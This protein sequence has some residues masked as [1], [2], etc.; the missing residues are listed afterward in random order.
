MPPKGQPLF[1]L[2]EKALLA[3]VVLGACIGCAGIS[4][5]FD[6]MA[7]EA[8]F[9]ERANAYQREATLRFG[10]ADAVLTSLDAAVGARGQG[11]EAQALALSGELL[12]A[13][14][15]IQTSMHVPAD[16][17]SDALRLPVTKTRPATDADA[18]LVG[19]DFMAHPRLKAAVEGAMSS[20]A[21]VLTNLVDFLPSGPGFFLFRPFFDRSEIS[22]SRGEFAGLTS[23]YLDGARFFETVPNDFEDVSVW[24]VDLTAAIGDA[25]PVFQAIAPMRSEDAVVAFGAFQAALP[26]DVAGRVFWISFLDYPSIDEFNGSLAVL[27]GALPLIAGFFLANALASRRRGQHRLASV[28]ASLDRSEQRFK[29]FADASADL[30]WEMDSELRFSF[31]SDQY[32]TLTGVDAS[33]MLGRTRQQTGIPNVDPEVWRRHLDDLAAHRPFRDFIHPRTLP[34][35]STSWISVNGKPYFSDDGVFQG[36]RGTGREVTAQ[37]EHERELTEAKRAADAASRAKSEFLASMSHEL[38]TP[39][40]AVVGFSHILKSEPVKPGVNDEQIEFAEHIHHSGEHLLSLINDLLDLSKIESGKD[41]LN[42][43]RVDLKSLTRSAAT[44]VQNRAIEAG[45]EVVLDVPS[46]P[47]PLLADRRKVLQALVNMLSNA[48]KFTASGGKTTLSVFFE[49]DGACRIRVQDTGIGIAEADIPKALAAFSQVENTLCRNYEGTGLGLPLTKSLIEQHGG[50]L[51]LESE[52]G[53]G[54]TV[55]LAFPAWR[56]LK[57]EAKDATATAVV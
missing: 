49:D 34:D 41:E 22:P 50:E 24:L 12:A 30:Y 11:S 7:A 55:T 6:L 2:W 35:G 57:A 19:F 20:N 38:R 17:S 29:D 5:N 37:I 4:L 21:T 10:S 32:L 16:R 44:M 33:E 42:E 52:V 26:I 27:C 51:R 23:L 25:K 1:K 36:Y 28:A 46:D 14:P 40:N 47:P 48:V 43:N 45:I 31:L 54:T 13:Y 3:F 9:Q 53:V 39:L 15:Y 8:R 56:S 18:G